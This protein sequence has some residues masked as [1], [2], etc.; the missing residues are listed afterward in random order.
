MPFYSFNLNRTAC[1]ELPARS[2]SSYL[3]V[4]INKNKRL[5]H[6]H[7]FCFSPDNR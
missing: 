2:A 3:G 5:F 7:L 6:T 4:L 1:F